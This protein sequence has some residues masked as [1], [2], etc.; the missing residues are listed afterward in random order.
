MAAS[1]MPLLRFDRGSECE[2]CSSLTLMRPTES[3]PPQDHRMREWIRQGLPIE[4]AILA[5]CLAQF[6][7]S[8]FEWDR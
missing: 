5:V 3:N 6:I 4:S 8:I 2:L 1:V 7:R